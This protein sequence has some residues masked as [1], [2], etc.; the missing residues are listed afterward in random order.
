MTRG[1]IIDSDDYLLKSIEMIDSIDTLALR[2][3]DLNLLPVFAA[4]LR[5]RS[6]VRAA[7]A[8][9]IG[10]PAV[11]AAL[12]RLRIVFGDP[13]FVRVPRGLEPTPRALEIAGRIAPALFAIQAS[14]IGSDHF[15]PATSTATL[16]LGMP[17]HLE[18]ATAPRLLERLMSIAP[19]IRIDIRPT[20]GRIAATMLDAGEL[21]LACGRIDRVPSWQRREVVAD[22]GYLCLFDS[23]RVGFRSLDL[24]RF[25]SVPQLLVSTSGDALGVVDRVLA[26]L[27]RT[28]NVVFTTSHFTTLP[29]ILRRMAA[30]ATLPEHAARFFAREYRLVAAPAPLAL[31]RYETAL[32]WLARN[33]ESAM[34]RWLRDV[35][36][37][38][39]VASV[40]ADDGLA[41]A[42]AEPCASR[43]TDA[44]RRT[45]HSSRRRRIGSAR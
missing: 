43:T 37:G 15:D 45:R 9:D 28:R 4:L 11:S 14:M 26:T 13:L 16:R 8:L 22:V 31:P 35:V 24:D 25:L 34:H 36:R 10:Q 7:S 40:S 21:D 3:L 27:G 38:V 19:G 41:G 6:T 2:G 23:R 5:E 1:I 44:P 29:L 30:I 18:H 42:A 20:N 33:E 32:V 12:A 17:D 39:L